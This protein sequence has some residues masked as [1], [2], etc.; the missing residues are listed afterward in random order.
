V[1]IGQRPLKSAGIIALLAGSSFLFQNCG[2]SGGSS[3]ASGNGGSGNVVNKGTR[4]IGVD[5]LDTTPAS[6]FAN[7]IA[8]AQAAGASY[9]ILG[10]G[11]NQIEAA[12]PSD[13]ATAGTYVDPSGALGTF[14]TQLPAAG[15]KLSLSLLPVSTN[16]N[17]MPSNLAAKA[18]D[19]S[20]VVCRFQKMLQFVFSKIPNLQ[21]VS[22]QFGNEID[23]YP[24]AN[25]VSFW[26]QYWNF[27]TQ[28]S[29]T[30]KS[31]RPGVNTS[32]VSTLYGAAGLSS[33]ALAQGGLQAIYNVADVV[34]VTY[35]PL[36]TDYT[37]KSPSVAS[38]DIPALTSV[39]P[40]Q[41]IYFNEIGYPSGSAYD[42]SS[43]TL[44]QQFISTVFSTWDQH[45]TQIPN[46]SF[47][48]LNDLSPSAAQTTATGYGLGNNNP[49][50][51]YL[52][53]LGLRTY[54]GADKAAYTQLKTETSIRGW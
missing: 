51:E 3:P 6:S 30:A 33:N 37:V 5:I 12:T 29:A 7:N 1:P 28:V 47:L 42:N 26:S 22:I 54:A 18:F 9:M 8:L 39:Y 43:E 4:A 44:Q 10:L 24:T 50:I 27:F 21:L 19:D 20:L 14:N 16:S 52:E 11:W 48:R 53:T 35:Y 49:F 13:C 34:V 2:G 41:P 25:Q 36:N 23:A 31:L 15:L 32:V 45:A 17:L 38:T 40:A 46:M